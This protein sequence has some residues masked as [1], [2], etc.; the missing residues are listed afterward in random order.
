MHMDTTIN[1]EDGR[2]AKIKA[3]IRVQSVKEGGGK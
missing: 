1:Y 3:D 2:V